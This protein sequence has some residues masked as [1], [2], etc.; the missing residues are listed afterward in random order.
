MVLVLT[1]GASVRFRERRVSTRVLPRVSNLEKGEARGSPDEL[2][3]KVGLARVR[4]SRRLRSRRA[5]QDEP[6]RTSI[7]LHK[8]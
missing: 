3:E 6:S 2:V 4:V 5:V 7:P 8:A 1:Q